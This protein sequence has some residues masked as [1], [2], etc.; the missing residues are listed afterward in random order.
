MRNKNELLKK[1]YLKNMIDYQYNIIEVS[2]FKK[3]I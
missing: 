1:T 2:E 3:I